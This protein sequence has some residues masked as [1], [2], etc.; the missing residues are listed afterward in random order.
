MEKGRKIWGR[1]GVPKDEWEFSRKDIPG[2]KGSICKSK[3]K[4]KKLSYDSW[5]YTVR[6]CFWEVIGDVPGK[7]D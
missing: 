1:P 5:V 7:V 6:N 4:T 2:R 3:G